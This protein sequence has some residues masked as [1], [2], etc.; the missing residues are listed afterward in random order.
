M[1][2]KKVSLIWPSKKSR[3]ANS[4]SELKFAE[5]ISKHGELDRP[6]LGGHKKPHYD[7]EPTFF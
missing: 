2:H 1:K 4:A 6:L 5:I 3:V 7:T